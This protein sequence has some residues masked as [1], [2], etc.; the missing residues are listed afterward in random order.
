MSKWTF[1]VPILSTEATQLLVGKAAQRAGEL[2]VAIN[3]A[4]FDAGLQLSAFLR[5]QNAHVGAMAIAMDKA[6]TSAGFGGRSTRAI[7]QAVA[8]MPELTRFAILARPRHTTLTGGVPIRIGGVLVGA[9]G[10]SGGTP[11]QDEECAIAGFA[12]IGADPAR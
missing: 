2:G 1:N 4:V 3:I 8:G 12:A 10:G 11:D 7:G 9:I 5:M 6:W